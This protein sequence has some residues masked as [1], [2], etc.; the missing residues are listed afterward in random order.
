MMIQIIINPESGKTNGKSLEKEIL[1]RFSGLSFD[2]EFTSGPGHATELARSASASGAH[3]IVAVGGDGIVNEVLNGI[4]GTNAALGIIP[5][6]TAND[7]ARHLGISSDIAASCDLIRNSFP[8]TIDTIEVNGR[9]FLTAGGIG[10]AGDVARTANR[11]KSGSTFKYS[12]WKPSGSKL[13]IFAALLALAAR[14]FEVQPVYL[15]TDGRW[16]V[17][18]PLWIMV[19]NQPRVGRFFHMSPEAKNN[20]GYFNVCM[21]QNTRNKIKILTTVI[22]VLAGKHE[23]LPDITAFKSRE[24]TIQTPKPVPFFGD[25]ELLCKSSEF[26]IRIQPLSVRILVPESRLDTTCRQ[27]AVRTLKNTDSGG[28]HELTA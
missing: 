10:L 27:H 12:S 2:L 14:K 13:Y 25:G 9:R 23:K 15:R 5:A 22:R 21:A 24:M 3:T 28:S 18:D 17:A 6:G 7:L 8:T 16:I 20:D 1:K 19:S 11:L 26:R 4:T